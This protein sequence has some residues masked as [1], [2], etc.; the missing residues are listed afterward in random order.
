[1]LMKT[2]LQILEESLVLVTDGWTQGCWARDANGVETPSM[3]DNRSTCFCPEGA[4][5]RSSDGAGF[6][7]HI[8]S[9]VDEAMQRFKEAIG[10]PFQIPDWND[11]P[12][13]TQKEVI[14]AFERAIQL[15]KKLL[16]VAV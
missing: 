15:E 7:D 9:N 8:T 14:A 16:E 1:M 12:E 11:I 6:I 13:R 4:I 2:T 10:T 5:L 3:N